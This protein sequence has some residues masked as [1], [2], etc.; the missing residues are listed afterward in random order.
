MIT[1]SVIGQTIERRDHGSI[2]ATGWLVAMTRS[3]NTTENMSMTTAKIV[4]ATLR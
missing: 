2:A 1:T 3:Y 4:A